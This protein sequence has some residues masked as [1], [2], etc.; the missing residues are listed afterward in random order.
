MFFHALQNLLAD[1]EAACTLAMKAGAIRGLKGILAR[2][3][4]VQQRANPPELPSQGEDS[5]EEEEEVEGGGGGGGGANRA[6]SDGQVVGEALAMALGSGVGEEE[7]GG[8]DEEAAA[9]HAATAKPSVGEG[10]RGGAG[11]ALEGGAGGV[12]H[13]EGRRRDDAEGFE[14]LPAEV[15]WTEEWWRGQRSLDAYRA[16]VRLM[17]SFFVLQHSG[18]L[19]MSKPLWTRSAVV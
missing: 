2:W 16:A 4:D 9:Q 15:T 17:C 6:H 7:R 1:N 10:A 18:L 5:S 11:H 3:V 14:A 12:G 13:N 8:E 19:H